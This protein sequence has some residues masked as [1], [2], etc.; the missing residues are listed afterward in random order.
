MKSTIHKAI[1]RLHISFMAYLIP[2]MV[3]SLSLRQILFLLTP[4][5]RWQPYRKVLPEIVQSLIRQRLADP[6]CMV[7]RA[8]LREGMLMYHFLRLTGRE[9]VLHIGVHPPQSERRLRAHCW[10]SAADRL[11]SQQPGSALAE[12]FAYPK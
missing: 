12:V 5:R 10:V 8:C 7:R 11:W 1:L 9:A 4:P 2:V 3:H 6:A